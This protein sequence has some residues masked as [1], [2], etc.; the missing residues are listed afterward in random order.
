MTLPTEV[1]ALEILVY[2]EGTA[3]P[4]SSIR[5]VMSLDDA[6]MDEH[7]ELV[8]GD[9]PTNVPIRIVV[10]GLL[11]GDVPGWVGSVG[12]LVLRPG[13]RRYVDLKMYR[14]GTSVA[15]S[16][17]TIGGRAL[18]TATALPD[19][20]VLVTG[21]FDMV[22]ES[23]PC[24]AS[25]PAGATC[26]G[27]EASAA[28][29]LFDV[30]TGAA[31]PVQGGTLE[32]RGGH[33]ATLLP[34]GRV[35]VA[36][37]AESAVLVLAPVG[38]GYAPSITPLRADGSTGALATFE[39]FDPSLHA[40]EEDVN[41]DGDPARGGFVGSA[42]SATSPGALNQE[43]FLHA[44]AIVP[45]V[46]QVL[47]VGGLGSDGGAETWEVFD[48]QR[49]G[50]Y[51]VH[52]NGGSTLATP[53]PLPGAIGLTTGPDG[54]GPSVWIFGG[55]NAG[56]NADLAEVWQPTT[57]PNG[58]TMVASE[59]SMFPQAPGAADTTHPEYSL[60]RPDVAAVG[61]GTHALVIGWLGPLCDPGG[62][63]PFFPAAGAMTALCAQDTAR[64][65]TVD[66]ETGETVAT[67]TMSPHAL[68]SAAQLD[69]G[70]VVV[71]GGIGSLSWTRQASIE[72]FTGQVASGEAIRS[73]DRYTLLTQRVLHATA[74]LPGGGAFT[75]G[76]LTFEA[77]VSG[78]TLVPTAEVLYMP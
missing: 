64:S 10:R 9:L 50:G 12:P 29:F 40:E 33:T 30:S 76:G 8:R 20:R 24:P 18:A 23:A 77:D 69:D 21:G 25:A 66:G 52:D 27:L 13:E 7:P 16:A 68:A 26:I 42:G 67:E 31:Y 38:T 78:V 4:A 55:G 60:V 6:D 54:M 72:L 32:A 59:V 5:T 75:V 73:P 44:A 61:G 71:V 14:L 56:S 15:V 51:G 74:A 41:R 57:D 47:L 28:A 58:A 35:L 22:D 63:V 46:G 70:R 34:D 53:R 37:G 62:S 36:G 49:P 65:F 43:R 1:E 19:G 2:T 39:V 11:A 3:E 48:V 45:G 17:G